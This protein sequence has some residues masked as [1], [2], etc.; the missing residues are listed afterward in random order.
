MQKGQNQL[1]IL[2]ILSLHYKPNGILARGF[3][4]RDTI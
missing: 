4:T 1:P 3:N 2:I